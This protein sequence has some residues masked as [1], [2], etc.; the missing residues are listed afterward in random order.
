MALQP[1]KL[2]WRLLE[3]RGVV[4][5][6]AMAYTVDAT[7]PIAS[8]KRLNVIEFSAEIKH[9]KI[10]SFLLVDVREDH[11]LDAS[12][13][14]NIPVVHLPLSSVSSWIEG[15]MNGATLARNKT[16]YCMVS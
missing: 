12:S 14:T 1:L 8:V 16:I 7:K 3:P 2:S 11:E 6:M 9:R 10:D 5:R 13:I 4:T 15:V